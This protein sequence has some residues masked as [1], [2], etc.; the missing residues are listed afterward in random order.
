MRSICGSPFPPGRMGRIATQ[1]NKEYLVTIGGISVTPRTA[2]SIRATEESN[3]S[4]PP[5]IR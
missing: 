1:V 4:S 3:L 2:A 5:D